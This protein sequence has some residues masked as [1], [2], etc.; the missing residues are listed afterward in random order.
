MS[1]IE[2]FVINICVTTIALIFWQMFFPKR[3]I[4]C[5]D[6]GWQ[7][8]ET[9]PD[10]QDQY[11]LLTDGYRVCSVRFFECNRKGQVIMPVNNSIV[12]HWRP[13]PFPPK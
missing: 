9:L 5:N 13:Y 1:E 10:N 6:E 8:I 7:L 11:I 2:R 3:R 12:T 4:Y